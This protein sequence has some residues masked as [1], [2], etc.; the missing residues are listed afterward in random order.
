MT[1]VRTAQDPDALTMTFVADFDASIDRVWQ[2]WQDPRQL[3]RWWGPPTWPATFDRHDFVVGGT[4]RYRMTGPDGETAPGWW[5]ITAIDAPRRLELV[6]GFSQPD[7]EPD[8]TQRPITAV[9]TAE[10]VD[11]TTRM[12]VVTRFVDVEHMEQML[13]M[14][15]DE[16][17]REAM[18]QIDGVLAGSAPG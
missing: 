14:S 11:G 12:T 7:G 2:L 10:E 8:P 5:Q 13:A 18:G 3:E 17:M 16:G 1:V 6:D 15:M 4:S 9:V